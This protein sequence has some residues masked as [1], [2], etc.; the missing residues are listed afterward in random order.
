MPE[1]KVMQGWDLREKFCEKKGAFVPVY[2]K[3]L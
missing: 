1:K 2:Y 3:I